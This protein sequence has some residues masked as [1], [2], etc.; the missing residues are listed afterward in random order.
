MKKVDA[1]LAEDGCLYPSPELARVAEAEIMRKRKIGV[2]VG[3]YLRSG[4]TTREIAEAMVEH[5][6]ELEI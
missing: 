5:W 3:R 6:D 4:L 1:W 2:W